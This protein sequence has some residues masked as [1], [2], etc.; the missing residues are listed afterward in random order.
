MIC[1]DYRS[2]LKWILNYDNAVSLFS[3]FIALG[4]ASNCDSTAMIY[5][6]GFSIIFSELVES[7]VEI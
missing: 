5:F 3:S 4:G 1:P 7:S 2:I 6:E